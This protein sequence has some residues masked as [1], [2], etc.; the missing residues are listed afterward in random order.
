MLHIIGPEEELSPT[1]AYACQAWKENPHI[2]P[3]WWREMLGHTVS[4]IALDAREHPP[5]Q[6]LPGQGVNLVL[7][8]PATHA[9]VAEILRQTGNPQACVSICFTPQPLA[10]P[11]TTFVLWEAPPE[12]TDAEALA[13][14]TGLEKTGQPYG[15]FDPS[16]THP[17]TGRP[18]HRWLELAAEAA[19]AAHGRRKRP[20]LRLLAVEIDLLNLAAITVTNTRHKEET[21]SALELAARLNLAVIG[22]PLT[23]PVKAPPPPEALQALM[24]L[25]AA[26]QTLHQ[27]L[28][29]WPVVEDKPLFSV[30]AQMTQGVPPWPTPHH[31]KHWE[32]H[33]W[34]LM[35]RFLAA[36]ASPQAG[37]LRQRG[38]NMGAWGHLLANFAARKAL[39]S[40][41]ASLAEHVPTSLAEMSAQTRQ[42][43]I[44]STI[45]G[46]A[47]LACPPNASIQDIQ[48]ERDF[49]DLGILFTSA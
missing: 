39:E 2:V 3:S 17:A 31:W 42:T 14:L 46:L 20:G 16:L 43:V 25:A 45:P 33:L 48:K 30:L 23:T 37:D 44:L 34:P 10:A 24:E 40:R 4:K 32:R 18:L 49:P 13:T 8:T 11:E 27:T 47:A 41:L 21:V 12:T 26:E 28:G 35:E 19:M 36:Q 22:L 1:R 15:L 6:N 7:T 38:Q 9:E 29:G 5:R